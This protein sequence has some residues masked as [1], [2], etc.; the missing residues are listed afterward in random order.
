MT[1][2]QLQSRNQNVE[3]G[4]WEVTYRIFFDQHG[5]LIRVRISTVRSTSQLALF[6]RMRSASKYLQRDPGPHD[7]Q[8]SSPS[9]QVFTLSLAVSRRKLLPVT[10][11]SVALL[12]K[13]SPGLSPWR[14]PASLP[15][16]PRSNVWKSRWSSTSSLA[17]GFSFPNPSPTPLTCSWISR[18]SPEVKTFR[19]MEG[20]SPSITIYINHTVRDVWFSWVWKIIPC[21]FISAGLISE[22]LQCGSQ[23][24][25]GRKC[26]CNW[27]VSSTQARHL[28]V[29]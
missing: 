24:L 17:K 13:P 12:N 4:I 8:V 19:W 1:F 27:A 23:V 9:F 21:V 2:E 5:I 28:N 29:V 18:S 16:L 11:L 6:V 22:A 25:F 14:A 10:V 7:L 3:T 20:N 26:C 15:A